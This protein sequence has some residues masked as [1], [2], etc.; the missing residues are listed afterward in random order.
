MSYKYQPKL[1][2][3][4]NELFLVKPAKSSEFV[5][6]FGED[7]G[8]TTACAGKLHISVVDGDQRT[9]LESTNGQKVAC[10]LNEYFMKRF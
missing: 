8:L 2:L 4:Y 5:K 6:Y 1:P 7:Y 10:I 3:K 9:F